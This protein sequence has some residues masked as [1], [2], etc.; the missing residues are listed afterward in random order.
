MIK[1]RIRIISFLIQINELIFF[2][3]K[4]ARVY[5][6]LFSQKK[7]NFAIDVGVNKGQTIFFLKK[8][9]KNTRI[10]GFEPHKD[11]YSK[12][13]NKIHDSKIKIFNLGCSDQDGEAVFK[14]NILSESSSFETVN[15]NSS[16]LKKKES[17]LGVKKERLVTNEYN[18]K[19]IRLNYFIQKEFRDL[20]IDMIKIDVEGHELK[21]LNGLFPIYSKNIIRYIQIESHEDD[22]Y[23]D[24]SKEIEKLLNENGFYQETSVKHGFGNFYDVIYKNK[25]FE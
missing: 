8:I 19:T 11:L 16:W 10:I 7:L 13:I 3:P 17:V 15:E 4:L 20:I 5:R 2:Y 25:Y 9:N 6:K 24:N 21:V 22:L 1:I 14:E 18:M 12:L 23:K